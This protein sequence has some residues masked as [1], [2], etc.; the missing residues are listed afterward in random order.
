MDSRIRSRWSEHVAKCVRE[1]RGR[2]NWPQGK[3]GIGYWEIDERE[4]IL[5]NGDTR[6]VMGRFIVDV[7]VC[8]VVGLCERFHM[9]SWSGRCLNKMSGYDRET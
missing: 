9:L 3:G 5:R 8:G 4:V 2:K 7:R 6:L 1:L